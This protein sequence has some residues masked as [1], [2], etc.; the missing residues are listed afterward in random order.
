MDSYYFLYYFFI[1]YFF[2]HTGKKYPFTGL[3]FHPEKTIFEWAATLQIPHNQQAIFFS[4]FLSNMFVREV[5]HNA[6]A[7]FKDPGDEQRLG[8]MKDPVYYTG[9]L[10]ESHSPFMQIYVYEWRLGDA[11]KLRNPFKKYETYEKSGKKWKSWTDEMFH[12]KY[13]LNFWILYDINRVLTRLL[14]PSN[15][16]EGTQ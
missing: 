8:M 1:Y 6:L 7:R 11:A 4:Q 9:Y 14:R 2:I 12:R 13:F 5:K 15:G 16:M 10:Q 3:Q